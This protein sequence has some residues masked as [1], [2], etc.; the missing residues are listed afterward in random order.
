VEDHGIMEMTVPSQQMSQDMSQGLAL[1]WW[2]NTKTVE[3][4]LIVD[5]VL[6]KNGQTESHS[7]YAKKLV[8]LKMTQV[9]AGAKKS[10]MMSLKAVNSLQM[11]VQQVLILHKDVAQRARLLRDHALTCI[12]IAKNG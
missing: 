12:L 5:A 10:A 11:N 1:N 6:I 9:F 8:Q 7:T 3:N 2:T 4:R